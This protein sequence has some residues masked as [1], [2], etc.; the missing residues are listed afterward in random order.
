MI[1]FHCHMPFLLLHSAKGI[2]LTVTI[3]ASLRSECE[4][5]RVCVCVCVCHAWWY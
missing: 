4:R 5:V 3:C 1:T 2:A